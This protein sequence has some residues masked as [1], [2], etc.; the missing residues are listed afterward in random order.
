METEKQKTSMK[1]KFILQRSAKLI[2][3][4][5]IDQDKKKIHKFQT[6]GM[7]ECSSVQTLQ[8]LTKVIMKV[9]SGAGSYWLIRTKQISELSEPVVNSVVKLGMVVVLK[10]MCINLP[11]QMKWNNSLYHENSISNQILKKK[12]S[13]AEDYNQETDSQKL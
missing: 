7:K 13:Q 1:Q 12:L 2:N 4:Q 5:S 10:S 3:I 9:N 8:S 11:I 6:L